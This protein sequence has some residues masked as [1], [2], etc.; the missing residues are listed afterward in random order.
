MLRLWSIGARAVDAR[1]TLG[2]CARPMSFAARAAGGAFQSEKDAANAKRNRR[3][4][5]R[6]PPATVA[7]SEENGKTSAEEEDAFNLYE[8]QAAPSEEAAEGM[9]EEAF[10][11]GEAT[12]EMDLEDCYPQAERDVSYLHFEKTGAVMP[13]PDEDAK[14]KELSSGLRDLIERFNPKERAPTPGR[15]KYPYVSRDVTKCRGCGVTLQSRRED[16]LGYVPKPKTKKKLRVCRRCWYLQHHNR[17]PPMREAHRREVFQRD[18]ATAQLLEARGK[19]PSDPEADANVSQSVTAD[20]T[21]LGEPSADLATDILDQELRGAV[22]RDVREFLGNLLPKRMCLVVHVVD[23]CDMAPESFLNDLASTIGDNEVLIVGNK[24]DLLPSSTSE[25]RLRQWLRT[26]AMNHCNLKELPLKNVQLVSSLRGN[27]RAA[28][29]AMEELRQHRDVFVVGSVNS[30]KSTFI[31]S[32]LMHLGIGGV[33]YNR[34]YGLTTS[35]VPGT[36]LDTISLPLKSG[37][38]LHDTPGLQLHNALPALHPEERRLVVPRKQVKPRIY[39]LR[40]G[41]S[42]FLGGLGRVDY[43]FGPPMFLSVCSS[44][45]LPLHPCDMNEADRLMAKRVGKDL[46]PPFLPKGWKKESDSVTEGASGGESESG[47][48]EKEKE[49]TWQLLAKDRTAPLPPFTWREF[50]FD[51]TSKKSHEAFADIVLPG[52]GWVSLT[53]TSDEP[54]VF[55]AAVMH[56]SGAYSRPPAMPYEASAAKRKTYAARAHGKLSG[57]VPPFTKYP[58]LLERTLPRSPFLRSRVSK[59]LPLASASAAHPEGVY[60][61]SSLPPSYGPLPLRKKAKRNAPAKKA[62]VDKVFAEFDVAPPVP[63][64]AKRSASDKKSPN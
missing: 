16:E 40:E 47:D 3:R 19:D 38:F 34:K 7:G 6:A 36:T 10:Y 59:G 1:V 31:N 29:D 25:L 58:G 61:A 42:I 23:L 8:L 52:V 18:S 37:G 48:L 26:A 12:T 13:D 54:V 51:Q 15:K 5:G 44:H 21:A 14:P 9:L 64:M 24:T 32:V 57:Y 4:R 33:R 39:R 17:E 22:A 45:M 49:R 56:G 41:K 11:E 43:L 35:P 50:V 53:G 30:G 55:H 62:E 28:L 20:V 27:V 46:S 60:A 63:F 2:R